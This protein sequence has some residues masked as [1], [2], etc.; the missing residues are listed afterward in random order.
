[1]G[2]GD[3]TLNQ[4]P[5]HMKLLLL[6]AVALFCSAMLVSSC[7]K[8]KDTT[9]GCI[10][11]G[12]NVTVK[13]ITLNVNDTYSYELGI[14]GYEDG[15]G[16]EQQAKHFAVS[17]TDRKYDTVVYHYQPAPGYI[18]EDTVILKS[19]RGSNG[20]SSNT[21]IAYTAILFTIGNKTGN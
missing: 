18:G 17:E 21:N 3:Q 2:T 16:I 10:L 1:M 19:S 20:S 8:D 5:T 14:F 13:N 11:P 15:A 12:Q 9:T 6:S 7:K 4:P